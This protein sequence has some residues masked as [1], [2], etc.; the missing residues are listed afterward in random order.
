MI[1]SQGRIDSGP[2]DKNRCDIG[3]SGWPRT[4]LTGERHGTRCLWDWHCSGV[5]VRCNT[6]AF[7][8]MLCVKVFWIKESN[9]RSKNRWSILGL[10]PGTQVRIADPICQLRYVRLRSCT[11]ASCLVNGAPM[12][13]WPRKDGSHASRKQQAKPRLGMDGQINS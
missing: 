7:L 9:A 11:L 5:L 10:V 6:H 1:L 3:D 8:W 2:K 13:P 12:S 4:V